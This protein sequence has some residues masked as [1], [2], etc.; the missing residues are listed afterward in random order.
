MGVSCGIVGLPNVGKTTIFGAITQQEVERSDY[1]FSTTGPVQG[2]VEVPD[3]RLHKI[4]EFIPTQKV[5]PAQMSVVDIPGLVSGASHGEGMGI[6]FLG[7]IKDS[8]V[9]LHV[10]RCFE[11]SGVEHVSGQ[12]D[13]AVDAE[14]IDEDD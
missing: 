8:D 12:V 5:V 1:M 14:I 6:G 9:L 7:A 2:G 13:P 3:D 10:V 11:K 4:A